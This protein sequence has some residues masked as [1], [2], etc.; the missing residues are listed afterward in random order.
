[1]TQDMRPGSFR[2]EYLL[3]HFRTRGRKRSWPTGAIGVAV[4]VGV[5]VGV[6]VGVTGS[7]KDNSISDRSFW[8]TRAKALGIQPLK[9][10]PA[11][12]NERRAE[13]STRVV[14]ML[15]VRLLLARCKVCQGGNIA[16]ICRQ[17]A[18]QAVVGEVPRPAGWPARAGQPG[19][20]PRIRCWRYP[21]SAD[22]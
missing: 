13:R 3:R 12:D 19:Y 1:M 5:T 17:A 6:A 8:A 7:Q 2:S 14:G 11:K 16:Q 4:A 22:L 21:R 15:P 18:R 20:A 9:R 10:L